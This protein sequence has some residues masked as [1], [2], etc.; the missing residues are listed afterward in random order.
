LV[1]LF[2]WHG[3]PWSP[4]PPSWLPNCPPYECLATCSPEEFEE[5]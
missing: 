5:E 4:M 2:A 1:K 3:K